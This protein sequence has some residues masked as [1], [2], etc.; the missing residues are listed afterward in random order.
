[1]Y[2][3][4]IDR[5]NKHIEEQVKESQARYQG[6]SHFTKEFLFNLEQSA[7]NGALRGHLDNA[8]RRHDALV[9]EYNALNEKYLEAMEEINRLH[10]EKRLLES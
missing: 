5:I 3:L 4:N 8:V 6:Q 9:D 2:K 7:K 1:M 10:N